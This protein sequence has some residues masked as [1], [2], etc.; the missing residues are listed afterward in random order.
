MYILFFLKIVLD[1]GLFFEVKCE[2]ILLKLI[3]SYFLK[4]H[5]FKEIYV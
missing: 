1:N 3:V 4:K 2:S 5:L